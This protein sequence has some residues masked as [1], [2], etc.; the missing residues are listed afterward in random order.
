M[1]W[2]GTEWIFSAVKRKVGE[3]TLSRSLRGLVAEG[4][5][6]FWAHDELREYGEVHAAPRAPPYP[7][8]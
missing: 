2:P 3:K 7:T 6:G 5:Q 1:R 8:M 4:H